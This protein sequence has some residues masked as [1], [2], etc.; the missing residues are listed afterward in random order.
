MET[1]IP[2]ILQ[3]CKMIEKDDDSGEE[4]PEISFDA[5]DRDVNFE[6]TVIAWWNE[7]ED[8]QQ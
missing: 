1:K 2:V 6:G 4:F 5:G 8:S 7:E 3:F